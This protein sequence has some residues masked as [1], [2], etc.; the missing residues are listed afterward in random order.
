[1]FIYFGKIHKKLLFPLL[2]P[3]FLK[4]RRF[5]RENKTNNKSLLPGFIVFLSITICGLF[6]LIIKIKLEKSSRNSIRTNLRSENM[7]NTF[8]EDSGE[9][10][11]FSHQNSIISKQ[12]EELFHQ[13]S[14]V[15]MK[16]FD[17]YSQ[18]SHHNSISSMKQIEL[19]IEIKNKQNKKD[20]KKIQNLYII[21]ISGFLFI[22]IGFKNLWRE[23]LNKNLKYNIQNLF[24]IIFF[25]IFSMIFLNFTMYSHQIISVIIIGLCFLTFFIENIIYHQLKL[26]DILIDM[27]YYFCVQ[28][29]Y[30]LS[31]IFG[32]KYLNKFLDSLYLFLFKIGII[33]LIPIT[34][35]GIFALFINIEGRYQ[36]FKCFTEISFKYFF[37]E[38]LFNCLFELGIWTTIY[39]LSPCHYIIYETVANILDLLLSN[40]EKDKKYYK[41]QQISFFILYPIISFAVLVFNEIIIL[42]FWGLNYNTKMEIMEREKKEILNQEDENIDKLY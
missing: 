11:E 21:L 29:C 16:Q 23:D 9:T 1:M 41:G 35:Y 5:I 39:Y 12:N 8:Y 36:V 15:S 3:I 4:I 13:N 22:A 25:I 42:N 38:I 32:K 30:C 40:F 20:T 26:S 31:D 17:E 14:R 6:Y 33:G 24:Q 10:E 7:L 27:V 2:F 37:L 34:I 19:D 28:F 18:Y